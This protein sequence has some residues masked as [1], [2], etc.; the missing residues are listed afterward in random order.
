L[1][2]SDGDEVFGGIV[3]ETKFWKAVKNRYNSADMTFVVTCVYEAPSLNLRF[4]SLKSIVNFKVRGK[5]WAFEL[6]CSVD[7]FTLCKQI[8]SAAFLNDD[9]I[10]DIDNLQLVNVDNGDVLRSIYNKEELKSA[11]KAYDSRKHAFI[12]NPT[13]NIALKTKNHN[14]TSLTTV[15]MSKDKRNTQTQISI[16]ESVKDSK[17][18][19]NVVINFRLP[20]HDVASRTPINIKVGS[21]WNDICKQIVNIFGLNIQQFDGIDLM[22]EVGT[23]LYGNITDDKTFWN[24]FKTKYRLANMIFVLKM[25]SEN[26]SQKSQN[27]INS[28]KMVSP[29]SHEDILDHTDT[30]SAISDDSRSNTKVTASLSS[31]DISVFLNACAAGDIPKLVEMI[32]NNFEI[33]SKD[34][35]GISGIHIASMNGNMEVLKWLV[36]HDAS[37]SIRDIDGMTPL[38]YACENNHVDIAL[39]LVRNGADTSVRNKAGL[40]SLHYVCMNGTVALGVL[41]RDYM[42]NVA[43][44]SGLTLLHCAADMGHVDMTKYL[45]DHG[46][47]IH[48]RDD[49][50]LTPLHLACIGGHIEVID[51]LVSRGA[52]YNTR[53]DQ[54]MSP[55]HHSCNEGNLDVTTWLINKGG[56]IF[57]RSDSSDTL[58]HFACRSGNLDLVKYLIE[59]KIDINARNGTGETPLETASANGHDELVE[60]LEDRGATMRIESTSEAATRQQVDIKAEHAMR[61]FESEEEANFIESL[62]LAE[63]TSY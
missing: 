63:P 9:F 17:V 18:E 12:V 49:D 2:D 50:G 26:S 46:A 14:S 45:L 53:D 54:G 40:T 27:G 10:S 29:Q 51:L 4:F 55:L 23:V 22:N 24:V 48:P 25:I 43:T 42:I 15:P 62:H 36:D 3:N 37:C 57:A 35:I 38:H 61:A 47:Q 13:K 28:G 5:L 32:K 56:N 1:I 16:L 31:V 11:L 6:D 34:D 39:F 60:W 44:T 59:N 58:L 19:K 7:W 20:M 8:A 30:I 52:Y 33:N 21:D 41:I